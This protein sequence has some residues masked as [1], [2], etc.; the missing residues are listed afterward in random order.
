VSGAALA[1]APGSVLT[2]VAEAHVEVKRDRARGLAQM[3]AI[4]R[5]G[6]P[7]VVPLNGPTTG[8]MIAVDMLP[9]ITPMVDA[10]LTSHMPWCGKTF[11]A[12]TAAGENIFYPGFV[13]VARVIFPMYRD[14]RREGD[15]VHAFPFRTY[16]GAGLQDPD[17]QVLKIDYNL[18]INPRFTMRR[19]LDELVQVDDNYYFGKAHY[20]LA[21]KASHLVFYFALQR[22]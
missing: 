13:P 1:T 12:A 14:Y 4:F 15:R 21:G 11:N 10:L 20:K 5:E 3:N 17:R 22:A 8:Q 16:L 2:R 19:I 18:P 6:T 9:G 7:P